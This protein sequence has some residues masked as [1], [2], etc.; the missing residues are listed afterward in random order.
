[1][2]VH[3]CNPSMRRL[4]QEDSIQCQPGL[5]SKTLSQNKESNNKILSGTQ[6]MFSELRDVGVEGGMC[7]LGPYLSAAW[8]CSCPGFLPLLASVSLF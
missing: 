3:T 2:L 7:Q 1:M 4:R 6:Q 5:H 8:G